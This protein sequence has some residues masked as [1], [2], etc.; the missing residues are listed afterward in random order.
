VRF[1]L[2][3]VKECFAKNLNAKKSKTVPGKIIF[4]MGGFP[5]RKIKVPPSLQYTH[6]SQKAK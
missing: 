4:F 5:R 6:Y 3:K 1:N 2:V